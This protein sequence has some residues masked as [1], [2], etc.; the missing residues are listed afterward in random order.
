MASNA[1][2]SAQGENVSL[3]QNVGTAATIGAVAGAAGAAASAGVAPAIAAAGKAGQ[4]S[5]P[6]SAAQEFADTTMGAG[7]DFAGSA[8]SNMVSN[9]GQQSAQAAKPA[10]SQPQACRSPKS[11]GC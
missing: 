2:A 1:V 7:A 5:M 6:V 10:D 8:A 11:S 4:L 9:P 3:T